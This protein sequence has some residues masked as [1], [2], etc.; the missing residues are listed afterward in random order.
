[1]GRFVALGRT[2]GP[3]TQAVAY[4]SNDGLTW[5]SHP[6]P[7]SDVG[8]GLAFGNGLFVGL[9]DRGHLS[10]ADGTSWTLSDP[11]PP[12]LGATPHAG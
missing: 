7:A 12:A 9:G 11:M 8:V 2:F 6:V 5:E 1:M 10:S 3:P 4:V